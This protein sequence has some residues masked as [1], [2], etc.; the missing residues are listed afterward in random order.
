MGPK[1]IAT[2]VTFTDDPIL[3]SITKIKAAHIAELQIAINA[4]RTAAGLTTTTF[5]EVNGTIS[6]SHLTSLRTALTQARGALGLATPLTDPAIT[7]G[8]TNVRALHV[9]E[10]RDAIK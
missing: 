6:A 7:P 9:Q 4:V 2:L 1:E 10:L 3:P 8:V 5:P